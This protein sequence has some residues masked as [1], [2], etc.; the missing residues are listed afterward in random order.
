M[1][2]RTIILWSAMLLAA[3]VVAVLFT[4]LM[5]KDIEKPWNIVVVSQFLGLLRLTFL[6]AL[7][8]AVV[9]GLPLFLF[10]RSKS[11]VGI[12]ACALG[13]FVVGAVGPAMLGLLSM[14]GNASYNAWSGGRA[15]I[16]NGVPTLAGWMEYAQS[17][18]FVGIIGLGGGLTFW[19]TM[20]LSGQIPP[21]PRV[22]E[23]PGRVSRAVLRTVAATAIVSTCAVLLLPSI[24]QDRSCHNLFRDGRWS[25]VPQIYADL[26]L[27]AD[28]WAALAQ[29]S[30]DFAVAHSLSLR[31][32]QQIRGGQ[33]LWRSLDLCNEA[34]VNIQI[35]DQPW[36]DRMD[37][38]PAMIK[39]TKLSVYEFKTGSIWNPLAHEFVDKINAR[40]PEKLVFRD[41]DGKPMSEIEAFGG[42]Q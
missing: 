9:F 27:T 32:D 26:D 40:W 29:I 12:I 11:C 2:M 42:R 17:V 24:V 6:V 15:T 8:H 37:H 1:R 4:G 18:G 25:I 33:L 39:G 36:L 21:K 14:F 3:V 35:K 5:T 30:T 31:S 13:G 28:D 20:R 19:L 7:A 23:T 38:A 41:R 16:V 34:G 22:A 10:L